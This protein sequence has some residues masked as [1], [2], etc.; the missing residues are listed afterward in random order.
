MV[1][2]THVQY[3]MYL[4]TSVKRCQCGVCFQLVL[5][6]SV[7]NHVTLGMPGLFFERFLHYKPHQL[8]TQP[9]PDATNFPSEE[10]VT[11]TSGAVQEVIVS[12]SEAFQEVMIEGSHQVR[13]IL[14]QMPLSHTT[15]QT[16][17]LDIKCR[18]SYIIS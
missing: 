9:R 17:R 12:T 2:E 8:Q 15:H 16:G 1:V 10:V 5:T 6:I 11:A 14:A 3:K 7:K 18:G 13:M 4:C